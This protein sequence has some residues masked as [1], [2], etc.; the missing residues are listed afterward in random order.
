MAI[1]CEVSVDVLGITCDST[2]EELKEAYWVL[3]RELEERGL[4]PLPDIEVKWSLTLSETKYGITYAH[5]TKIGSSRILKPTAIILNRTLFF[6]L[7]Q[8]ELDVTLRHEAAHAWTAEHCGRL[9]HSKAWEH[10]AKILGDTGEV[11]AGSSASVLIAAREAR[12]SVPNDFSDLD[13]K[14]VHSMRTSFKLICK[15]RSLEPTVEVFDDFVRPRFPQFSEE[16][17]DLARD[18]IC[19]EVSS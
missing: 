9:D 3:S 18:L 2:N 19:G 8:L 12:H 13:P 5:Y 4:K 10:I 7:P 6:K 11:Y 16:A 14:Q 1:K 15:N 17:I